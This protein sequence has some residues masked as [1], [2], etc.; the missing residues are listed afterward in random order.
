[1]VAFDVVIPARYDSTRLPGKP[2]LNIAG[3]TL[4][5][6]VYECACESHAS[7]VMIATDDRRILEAVAKFGGE[8]EMTL[9]EHTSGTDRVAELIQRMSFARD[10]MVVNLQGDEPL[11]PGALIDQVVET[12]AQHPGAMAATACWPIRKAVELNDPN[13]VKVVMDERGYALYFSRAPIPYRRFPTADA[14]YGYRHI[15]LYAYR[16]RDLI[17]FTRLPPAQLEMTEGLEQLRMLQSGNRIA[18]CI[19]AHQ[20]GEG[21]DTPDDLER[22]RRRFEDTVTG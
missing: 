18:V 14:P 3:K 9:R 15:G 17:A 13:V 2:L 16:A 22:V 1:M 10:R 12:L 8:A 20:P 19:A 11:M 21:V 6:R 4:I 7:Q 5:H